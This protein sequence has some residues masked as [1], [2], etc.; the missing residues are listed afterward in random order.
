MNIENDVESEDERSFGSASGSEDDDN[1]ADDSWQTL[2]S[3]EED[4]DESANESD[5][6]PD[7]DADVQN[8]FGRVR[9]HDAILFKC[10]A[11]Y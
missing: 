10:L 8:D 2:S 5:D 1:S 6:A 4:E 3:D 11:E 7:D 9:F